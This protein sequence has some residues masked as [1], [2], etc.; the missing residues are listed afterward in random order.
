MTLFQTKDGL[1]TVNLD[2]V[3]YVKIDQDSGMVEIFLFGNS[4]VLGDDDAIA[5][6]EALQA[7]SKRIIR[8][9]CWG[10]VA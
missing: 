8:A 7:A 4:T 6:M 1:I 5:F 9:S 10:G 2:R 3:D